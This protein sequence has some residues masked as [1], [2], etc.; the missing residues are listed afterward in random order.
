[1]KVEGRCYQ[2]SHLTI[3][4]NLLKKVTNRTWHVTFWHPLSTATI[5]VCKKHQKTL[6]AC[7]KDAHAH[8]SVCEDQPTRSL[9]QCCPRSAVAV[10]VGGQPGWSQLDVLTVVGRAPGSQPRM[11]GLH[12]GEQPGS[13]LTPAS[14]PSGPLLALSRG[15]SQAARS[16]RLREGSK[17]SFK[18]RKE[19]RPDHL[20]YNCKIIIRCHRKS[21]SKV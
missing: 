15:E 18:I 21:K 14:S 19:R 2:P 13:P 16:P 3:S 6:R 5:K 1:M 7:S 20:K 12:F 10:A 8:S 17:N 4:T 11:P 9:A